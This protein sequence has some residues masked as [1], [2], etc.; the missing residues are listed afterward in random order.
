MNVA[1]GAS[2][3]IL[4]HDGQ[5]RSG[6]SKLIVFGMTMKAQLRSRP[7]LPKIALSTHVDSTESGRVF[8]LNSFRLCEFVHVFHVGGFDSSESTRMSVCR[9]WIPKEEDS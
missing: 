8:L 9:S 2:V 1:T 3:A 7:Y 4:V 6:N 5:L